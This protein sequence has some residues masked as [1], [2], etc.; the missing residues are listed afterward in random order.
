[1]KALVVKVARLGKYTEQDVETESGTKIRVVTRTPQTGPELRSHGA[2]R[3]KEIE[4]RL[5]RCRQ[6]AVRLLYFI[7]P[8]EES[9]IDC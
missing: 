2:P 4:E 8:R 1:M 5:S 3:Y 7:H 9:L 6:F